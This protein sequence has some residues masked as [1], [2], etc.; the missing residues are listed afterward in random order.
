MGDEEEVPGPPPL[1]KVLIVVTSK[2]ALADESP[3]GLWLGDVA[4]ACEMLSAHGYEFDFASPEGTAVVDQISID[5]GSKESVEWYTDDMK[6]A[7][8]ENKKLADIV[9]G[10]TATADYKALY[11][12][13]GLGCFFDYPE[14]AE[15]QGLITAFYDAEK[16]VAAV[17]G[18]TCALLNVMAG[19]VKFVAE[20]E[21]TGVSTSE[22]GA[23]AGMVGKAVEDFVDV[24]VGMEAA[25]AKFQVGLDMESLVVQSGVLFTGKNPPSAGDLAKAIV[26]YYDPIKAEF[27]PKREALLKSRAECVSMI[28][29]ADFNFS[30]TLEGL[31]KTEKE[32]G[33]A[34]DKI[35]ALQTGA[36]SARDYRAAMLA[37]IDA[38]LARNATMRQAALDAKAAA[39]AAE[40]EE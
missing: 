7:I 5:K 26:Y 13:G 28:E 18:G 8:A 16:V 27:E 1:P 22:L 37:D 24:Q 25:G 36:Q 10:G 39:A 17:A 15:L 31:K 19:D 11:I 40:A 33:A 20:K 38:K 9:E 23:I 4:R 32:G 14:C 35:E 2:A 34:A 6:A 21:V 12:A 3:T 29:Q 30:A